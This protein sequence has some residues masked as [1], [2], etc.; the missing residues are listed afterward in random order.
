MKDNKKNIE[1]TVVILKEEAIKFCLRTN[2]EII[3]IRDDDL[4][5]QCMPEEAEKLL[6][7]I[8]N[9]GDTGGIDQ[10]SVLIQQ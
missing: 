7:G 1:T 2:N 9:I 3:K 10:M 8:F 6:M 4:T 5:L